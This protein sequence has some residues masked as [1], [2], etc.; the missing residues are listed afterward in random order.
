MR[1]IN[2]IIY[3][4]LLLQ[5]EEAREQGLTKL[6]DRIMNVINS[7]DKDLAEE[8]SYSQLKEDFHRDLWKLAKRH[9]VF[10]DLE[11]VDV[12]KLDKVIVALAA[13]TID[14]LE[15][16]LEVDSIVKGAHEPK[17]FGES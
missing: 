3:Q 7:E 15:V 10:Y 2:P 13:K 16:E 5:A 12:L 4:K 6:A 1:K 14:E 8:Y 17:L 9:I 11:S